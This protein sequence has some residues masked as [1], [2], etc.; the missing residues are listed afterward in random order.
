ML[1]PD[2]CNGKSMYKWWFANKTVIMLVGDDFDTYYR[3][4]QP[5]AALILLSK[6]PSLSPSV[7]SPRKPWSSLC[8]HR[9]TAMQPL[10]SL[11]NPQF[12]CLTFHNFTTLTFL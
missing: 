3:K 2:L 5:N 7:L 1:F 10:M 11:P 6:P 12:V 4:K 8:H 9:R